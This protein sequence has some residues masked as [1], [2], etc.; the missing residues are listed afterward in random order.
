MK[1]N[2]EGRIQFL[3]EELSNIR[4]EISEHYGT[5]QQAQLAGQVMDPQLL[6]ELETT[7]DFIRRISLQRSIVRRSKPSSSIHD[8]VESLKLRNAVEELQKAR[9]NHVK[10]ADHV[11]F[12][13]KKNGTFNDICQIAHHVYQE[14]Q[15]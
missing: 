8:V 9:A 3:I 14:V 10:Q 1:T 12:D 4:M 7:T 5:D 13:E 6:S 2:V 15:R 11:S